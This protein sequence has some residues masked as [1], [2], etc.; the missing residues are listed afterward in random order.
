MNEA[1]LEESSRQERE[2]E[3]SQ[4]NIPSMKRSSNK[5]LKLLE[6][7]GKEESEH[8]LRRGKYFT[9]L[10]H[11]MLLDVIPLDKNVFK[12]YGSFKNKHDIG[13]PEETE[14]E[15]TMEKESSPTIREIL[16]KL[17]RMISKF[18]EIL[19]DY[20]EDR[21]ELLTKLNQ[22]PKEIEQLQIQRDQER[23]RRIEQLIQNSIIEGLR[24]RKE[25]LKQEIKE[26]LKHEIKEELKQEIQEELKQEIEEKW[27]KERED[28]LEKVTNLEAEIRKLN[29]EEENPP[30]NRN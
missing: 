17:E 30:R 8:S 11:F 19:S 18:D 16:L 25:D 22:I 3:P 13:I 27:K 21:R 9:F 29:Q 14:E 1:I 4:G 23:E 26:D 24:G 10:S 2:S 15:Q 20:D 5:T 12:N 7:R 28:L 6:R